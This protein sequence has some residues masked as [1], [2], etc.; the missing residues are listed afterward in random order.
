MSRA[1]RLFKKYYDSPQNESSHQKK[2]L[3][4]N[5][6]TSEKKT[7]NGT[8]NFDLSKQTLLKYQRKVV[9]SMVEENNINHDSRARKQTLKKKGYELLP[10]KNKHVAHSR[11]NHRQIHNIIPIQ[12]LALSFDNTGSKNSKAYIIRYGKGY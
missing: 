7:T 6:Y 3:Q 9:S 5:V 2:M 12:D 8:Q 4:S 1:S 10:P 11:K